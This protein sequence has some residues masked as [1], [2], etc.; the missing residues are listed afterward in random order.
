VELYHFTSPERLRLIY[1]AG[2]IHV[3]ESNI[4][5]P[6]PDWPPFG[7]HVGPFV[8]WLTDLEEVGAGRGAGL[9]ASL[10]GTDKTTVRITVEVPDLDVTW[11]PDFRQAH[12]MNRQ[13]RRALEKGR[14]PESWFV[15]ERPISRNEWVRVE[16]LG[17]GVWAQVP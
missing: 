13:W 7:E 5:S 4:G 10:D 17:A 12:G 1:A 16:M 2:A 8:V 3:T 15:V 11:W 9:D 14:D 6:R